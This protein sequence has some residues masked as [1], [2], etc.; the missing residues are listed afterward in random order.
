MVH[1]REYDEYMRSSEW[2][3]KADLLKETRGHKCFICRRAWQRRG[4]YLT[5]HHL[6]YT[7]DGASILGREAPTDLV[8]LCKLH[9]KQGDYPLRE[10]KRDRR[11]YLLRRFLWWLLTLPVRLTW[12][13]V[14]RLWRNE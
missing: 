3:A 4:D 8:V 2:Q 11:R 12:G 7:R 14:V 10:I 5:V 1:S 9:H 13:V 6:C